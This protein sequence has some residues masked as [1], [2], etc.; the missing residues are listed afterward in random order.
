[1]LPELE[2][3]DAYR[4]ATNTDIEDDNRTAIGQ[5]VIRS[6]C[7]MKLFCKFLFVKR[8][9]YC[10]TTYAKFCQIRKPSL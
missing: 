7:F 9:D 4:I 3:D 1:M 10:M 5:V 6:L 2:K 8:I